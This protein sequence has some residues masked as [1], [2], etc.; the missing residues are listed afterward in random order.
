MAD[1]GKGITAAQQ[2]EFPN[3]GRL[4]CWAYVIRKMRGVIIS[5]VRVLTFGYST[6]R[7]PERCARKTA[8][9]EIC[10]RKTAHRVIRTETCA[11][12]EAH[13]CLQYEILDW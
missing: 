4:M 10:A 13:G 9:E 8:H 1:G 7:D 2:F 3:C 6:I 11:Q 12:K 5:E